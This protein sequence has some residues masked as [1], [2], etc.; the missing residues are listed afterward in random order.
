MILREARL[1]DAEAIAR[2]HVDT[3]RTTYRGIVPQEYLARLSYEQRE[4]SWRQ[5]LST[6]EDSHFIYVI[7]DRAGQIIGFANGGK[8]RTGD[9]VY[10][11][12]LYAIYIIDTCQ[13]QGLGRRLTRAVVERLCEVGFH[14]MLVWVLAD[15]PA[16]RFYEALG[17][18][19]VYE[20][21]IERGGVM[22]NEF[23]Y[24]WTDT[25]FFIAGH[26]NYPSS[27]KLG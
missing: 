6:A 5:M 18:Q 15:N 26:S 21:Q 7:E 27:V 19:K 11:G 1:D 9:S 8:E 12:E 16:C 14:S 20:K 25:Q 4:R 23:A 17:G 3:W 24:G 10:K 2:V 22:L 13:R